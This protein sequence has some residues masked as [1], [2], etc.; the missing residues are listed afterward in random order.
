[1]MRNFAYIIYIKPDMRFDLVKT[2]LFFIIFL[3]GSVYDATA[4][5]QRAVITGQVK[6]STSG[7]PLEGV[8]V[9]LIESSTQKI[10]AGV[11]TTPSGDFIFSQLQAGNYLLRISFLGYTTWERPSIVVTSGQKIQLRNILLAESAPQALQE[12][13]IQ[14]ARPAMRMELDRKVFD[15]RQSIISQGGSASELLANIPTLSV[16]ANG[17]V[18]MR[19]VSNVTVLIDGKPSALAGSNMG[20]Y[21]QSLPANSI[22]RVELLT[23]PSAKYDPSGQGGIINIVMKKNTSSG[24]NGNLTAGLGSY[25]IYNAGMDINQRHKKTNYY[26][27]YHFRRSNS[28]GEG[29]NDNTFADKSRVYNRVE[30]RWQGFNNSIRIGTDYA[31]NEK[32]TFNLSSNINIRNNSPFQDLYYTY[33]RPDGSVIGSSFRNSISERKSRGADL[34][35]DYKRL[36]E[37]TG[38]SISANISYGQNRDR[39][40]QVFTQT[41]TSALITID[42]DRKNATAARNHNINI[43]ADYVLAAGKDQK[44]EA[45]YRSTLQYSRQYQVS[46]TLTTGN[47]YQTDYRIS[48]NFSM[49]NL[50][51]A[52]Y[53]NYQRNL[54]PYYSLQ[55]GLRAE[56]AYLHTR[57]TNLNPDLENEND[58]VSTG[59]LYYFRLYPSVFILREL[60]KGKTMQLS[61]SRR[62][63]RPSGW[64]V[65]PFLDVSN[66]IHFWR[67]NAHLLPED[68]HALELSYMQQ[69][70]KLSLTSTLYHRMT[71]DV[72]QYM[73]DS[74]SSSTN[75]IYSTVQNIGR[76]NA[77]GIEVVTQI[78]LGSDLNALLNVNA[79]Y[80]SFRG[81][82]GDNSNFSK[83]ISWD[84][85]TTL[86]WKLLEKFSI[87]LKGGYESPRITAQGKGMGSVTSDAGVRWSVF[88]DRASLIFNVRN[89]LNRGYI[90]GEIRRIGKIQTIVM[91][92]WMKGPQ[93]GFVFNYRLGSGSSF[94]SE[95]NN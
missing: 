18:S 38:E 65:N 49:D 58:R 7:S 5:S 85:N 56:Q 72:F 62:V 94:A 69:W 71:N 36:F 77:S 1:M 11:L 19:G 4:Q 41:A 45:G 79:N 37:R 55:A 26:L 92:N 25:M 84:A 81:G 10:S 43:Q 46:D 89:I 35:L 8:S 61:Y 76:N 12:V 17:N 63:N 31:P 50:V 40:S 24:L 20:A 21:L 75:V 47:Q 90:W 78:N 86:N 80:Q 32:N 64:Q 52:L 23:N 83:G 42:P 73:V 93:F 68:I 60:S 66:P 27:G 28:P 34:N 30:G 51:H 88:K 9:L 22:E 15:P 13:V 6:D 33:F 57:H 87:Q 14:G 44:L 2:F 82:N 54:G 59:R 48:N 95:D 53:L 29:Y 3:S 74:V 16:D 70:E 39:G 67:G 91:D